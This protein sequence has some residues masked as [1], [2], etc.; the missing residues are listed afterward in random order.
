LPKNGKKA[1]CFSRYRLKAISWS[2]FTGGM[3][4]GQESDNH[5]REESQTATRTNEM[6]MPGDNKEKR[7]IIIVDGTPYPWIKEEISYAEVVTLEFPDYPQHPE[8]NYSVKYKHGHNQKP[9]G[10]L[11]PGGSIK[12]KNDMRF[13]VSQTGQS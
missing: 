11:S 13:Y 1:D 6:G 5:G 9:E 12:V 4:N 8:I 2:K 7:V 10:T 3:M